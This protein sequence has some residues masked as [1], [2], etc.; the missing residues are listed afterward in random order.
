L[1]STGCENC[2]CVPGLVEGPAKIDQ[3]LTAKKVVHGHFGAH[4]MAA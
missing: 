4:A 3:T 1:V 2:R